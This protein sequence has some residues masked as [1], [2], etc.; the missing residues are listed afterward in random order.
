MMRIPLT[1]EEAIH[2]PEFPFAE[3]HKDPFDRMLAYP[4]IANGYVL[5]SQDAKMAGYEDAGLECIW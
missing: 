1:P 4:C 5:V 3:N 2:Y